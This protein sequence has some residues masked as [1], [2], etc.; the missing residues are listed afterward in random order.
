MIKRISLLTWDPR[1]PQVCGKQ[2][3]AAFRKL[4]LLSFTKILNFPKV[5]PAWVGP[6]E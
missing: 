6:E 1:K 3:S 4:L 2:L 5:K